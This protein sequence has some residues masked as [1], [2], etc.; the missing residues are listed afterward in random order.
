MIYVIGVGGV[1]SW[2][3]HCMVKLV[4]TSKI[5]MVDGDTLEEKNLDRQLFSEEHIGFNKSIALSEKLGGGYIDRWYSRYDTEHHHSDWLMCCVD[6]NP[7]RKE[8]LEACDMYGCC[9]IFAANEVHSS[10]AYV[11]KPEWKNIPQLDPRL[12]YTDILSDEGGNVAARAAGCTGEAQVAN[13]QLVT[14]NFMAA[15]LAAHL[16]VVW[17]MEARKARAETLQYLPTRLSN[18]LTRNGFVL[19]GEINKQEKGELCQQQ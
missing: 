16:F 2:L 12:Y 1:G 15:S 6:N 19:R 14:A 4:D 8:V 7:G 9:A 5:V 11:Y 17:A 10:E 3:A 13:R 18:N